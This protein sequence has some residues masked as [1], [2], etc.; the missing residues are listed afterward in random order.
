M[1]FACFYGWIGAGLTAIVVGCATPS[2]VA[3]GNPSSAQSG[4]GADGRAPVA[5]PVLTPAEQALA[6]DRAAILGLAGVFD[7]EYRYE[8]VVVLRAGYTLAAPQQ[9]R[10]RE[11]VVVVQ[12]TPERI[13]LQHL[14][15]VGEPALVV[16]HWRQDWRHAPT[17]AV[18]YVDAQ[19][20]RRT[21]FNL[22]GLAGVWTRSVVEA[23][24]APAYTGWGRW[25][26]A[27]SAIDETTSDVAVDPVE[28]A[29][30]SGNEAEATPGGGG[31]S[32]S[33]VTPVLAPLPRREAVRQGDYEVLWVEDR[34][35][36][37]PTGWAQEQS[38]TKSVF[39]PTVPPLVREAGVVNYRRAEGV[40]VAAAEAYW[41][42]VGP[43]WAVARAAWENAFRS[44]RDVKIFDEVNGEP[45]WR[46]LFG[47][48]DAAAAVGQ[49]PDE[50]R[51]A[52]DAV[53]REYVERR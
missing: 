26:H 25:T 40:D 29:E 43:Y 12:D 31:A 52:F 8:E 28:G 53:L 34:V 5:A 30:T 36:Q 27:G 22:A 39:V 19:I 13:V 15:L 16:K 10:A 20:W 51:P 48:V 38:L 14:L 44:S 23:D 41:R 3:P 37:T 45:R 46:R 7:V 4:A 17:T 24:G 49:P 47:V 9:T 32:W 11:W 33:S 2:G 42:R 50:T 6:R 1:R 18:Q 21:P 35:T